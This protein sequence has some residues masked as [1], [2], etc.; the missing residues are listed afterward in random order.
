MKYWESFEPVMEPWALFVWE[1]LFATR[2]AGLLRRHRWETSPTLQQ[3]W[4][5]DFGR[6]GVI[7]FLG[8]RHANWIE[9]K[10]EP[11]ETVP[12]HGVF[13]E[14]EHTL[15]RHISTSPWIR[16]VIDPDPARA[17]LAWGGKGHWINP[18]DWT[19]T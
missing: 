12:I 11:L 16:Y 1:D 15:R 10:W 18:I 13:Y 19:V 14:D 4:R 9:T 3:I 8:Q 6:M 2:R 7:T 5:L 17:R